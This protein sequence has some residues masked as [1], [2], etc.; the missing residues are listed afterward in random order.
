MYIPFSL[1]SVF[2]LCEHVSMYSFFM[3][4]SREDPNLIRKKEKR[5]GFEIRTRN[6]K[7]ILL[8]SLDQLNWI[9]WTFNV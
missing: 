4:G 5:K 2:F 9:F 1:I 7:I 3:A 8:M 6:F